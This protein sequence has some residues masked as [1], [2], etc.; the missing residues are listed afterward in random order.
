[1]WSAFCGQRSTGIAGGGTS[2]VGEVECSS[3]EFLCEPS[4]IIIPCS[5]E[6]IVPLAHITP[7]SACTIS[8]LPVCQSIARI[9]SCVSQPRTPI[10][11]GTPCELPLG[12]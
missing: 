6:L 8:P 1:M 11:P 3:A 4:F 10:F 5:R 9:W 2:D 7:C 12:A